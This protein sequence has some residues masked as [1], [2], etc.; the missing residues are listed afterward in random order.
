MKEI[1]LF[2]IKSYFKK[3]GIYALLVLLIAFGVFGGANARFSIDENIF[4][5]SPYQIAFISTFLSLTGIFFSTL[6]ASQLVFREADA[7]FEL[8]LFSTPIHK[9]RFILGRYAALFCISFLCVLILTISFFVG[10]SM[11]KSSVKTTSFFLSYYLYPIILFGFINTFFVTAVLSFVGWISKNKMLVYVS[12][13]LLYI[14]YMV[15]L[16]YS[17]SP[18]MAQSMPQSQQAQ[19]I[20]AFTDPFGFSAF[21]QQTAGWS[22]AQRNKQVISLSGVFLINRLVILSISIGLI[23]ICTNKFSFLK[24][25]K[26]KKIKTATLFPKSNAAVIYKAVN[27]QHSFAAQ[28]NAL[29]SFTKI[30]LTY[31]VKTVPFVL[32]ALALLFAVGMEMYAEIEKGIRIPQKYSSSGLMA[33]TIIQNFHGLCV[34]AVLY[35]AHE[36]YWRSRDVNFFLIEN[37]TANFNSSFFAKWLSLSIVI[38]FFSLLMIFEGMAFQFLYQY[39]NI[40]WLVY[41]F[42]FLLCTLPL[43]LLGGLILLLQK[44]INRKYIGLGLTAIFTLL[45][46]TPM[47]K[48]LLSFPLLKFLHTISFDYSDMNGFGEYLP[49]FIQR[50]IFGFGVIGILILIFN[51]RKSGL[52]KWKPILAMALFGVMI[53][54]FGSKLLVGYQG[55][56]TDTVLQAQASYEKLYRK[57]QNLPQPI[58]TAVLTS[59]D[60]YPD[61][62]AYNIKG[63]Y[64]LENK[65]GQRINNILVNFGDGFTIND[66]VLIAGEETIAVKNQHQLITLRQGILPGQQAKFRFDI[67]YEWKAINGHQSFNAIVANGSFMRISR[68]YPVFGYLTDNEIQEKYQ[69][70]QLQLGEVTPAKPY[71]APKEPGNDFIDLDMTVSTSP[72]QIAIGMGELVKEW[73][74]TDRKYFQYKTNSPIPFRFALSSARY[75]VKKE[76]Y[77]GKSFEIYYHSTHN[78]NVD[79]LLKNAKLTMDYCEANFGVYPF[80]TIRFAEISGF[81][82][83][84]AATA[85]PATVYMTEDMIFHSNLEG[86]RQQDVINELAGHELSHLW[87]GNNQISPDRRDGAAMLTETLAMYTEMMMI[88]KMYGKQKMLERVKM[89]LNIYNSEKGF[90]EE[91]PLYKVKGENSHISYSKGAVVMY[92]LSELIG[93]EK[94]N[95]A[96]R[97]FLEE[98]RYPGQKPITTDL[99]EELYKLTDVQIHPEITAMFMKIG[100]LKEIDLK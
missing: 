50:L 2:D 59:V 89:H 5:N 68:Y 70:K 82:R 17:G 88:K 90:T 20:A 73:E 26:R 60:L 98:H 4:Q 22:V 83:G 9:K 86:D 46:A 37:S 99:I 91:Q 97:N 61:K 94:V 41:G 93:E 27:T 87:W 62:N 30:D 57:Y 72:G 77:K 44:V 32:T 10:Q 39:P 95:R 52:R 48:K 24:T 53:F 43:I 31:I 92:Q 42:I 15:A 23:F 8:L 51:L 29:F 45:M 1:F 71:D 13:L 18:L 66:A 96:L 36:I 21:F 64:L 38:F 56:N 78:E 100:Q 34:I 33:S 65:S 11:G 12:G 75:A 28:A 84:F 69:R 54:Y 14:F 85:Y 49:V 47:G 55:K 74:T 19:A 80:K 3:R 25:N 67:G 6:F 7:R 16:V 76:I 40:E 35:Y 79:H 63:G 58:I 81:T